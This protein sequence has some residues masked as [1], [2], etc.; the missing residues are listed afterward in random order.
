[1]LRS[2]FL[3]R[4][5]GSKSTQALQ[6]KALA[7]APELPPCDF[8]PDKYTGPSHEQM[9]KVRA[10]HIN[11][12]IISYYR[13]PIS[14]CQGKGAPQEDGCLCR[15]SAKVVHQWHKQRTNTPTQL[16]QTLRTQLEQTLR[17]Q[18][19]QGFSLFSWG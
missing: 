8:V 2:S 3:K 13:N 1:M 7:S 16:E 9:S 11:P 5:L 12:G 4:L 10:A 18:L 6:T 17:T 14:I 15:C 19:E